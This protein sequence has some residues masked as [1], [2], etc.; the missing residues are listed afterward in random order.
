MSLQVGG[1]HLVALR[2][3]WQHRLEHLARRKATVQKDQRAPRPMSLVVE[4]EAV[5]L[6]VLARAL[7]LGR[8]I[9][10][11]RGAPSVFRWKTACRIR[12]PLFARIPS[13][14]WFCVEPVP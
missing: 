6:G 12:T 14:R 10:L 5:N 7:H 9:G 13:D 8:Q 4:L 2:E 11:H 1:D 3:Q